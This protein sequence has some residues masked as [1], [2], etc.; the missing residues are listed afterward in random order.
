MSIAFYLHLRY[1]V[2]CYHRCS[3]LSSALHSQQLDFNNSQNQQLNNK[4]GEQNQ[5]YPEGEE[6][7]LPEEERVIKM[8]FFAG[9]DL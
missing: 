8:D 1:H 7:E 4:E 9:I 3:I 2:V 6:G 5:N